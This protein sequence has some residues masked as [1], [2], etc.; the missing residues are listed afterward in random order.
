MKDDCP[1]LVVTLGAIGV[2]TLLMLHVIGQHIPGPAQAVLGPADEVRDRC[3]DV[4]AEYALPPVL[5]SDRNAPN[6]WRC[7]CDPEPEC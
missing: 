7:L 6:G 4:C 2:L 1:I 3:S 5:E